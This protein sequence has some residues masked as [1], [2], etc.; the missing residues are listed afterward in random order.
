MKKLLFTLPLCLLLISSCNNAPKNTSGG[1]SKKADKL[2]IKTTDVTGVDE[3]QI[4]KETISE[5]TSDYFEATLGSQSD[6]GYLAEK[7][8]A[9]SESIKN[10]KYVFFTIVD[11]NSTN[12]KFQTSTEFLNFMSKHGYELVT[13]IPNEYGG[14]YTFKKK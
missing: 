13:Q 8:I 5:V 7:V 3:K 11:Q 9:E 4:K 10:F 14:D 6:G 12:I 1:N 2:Y